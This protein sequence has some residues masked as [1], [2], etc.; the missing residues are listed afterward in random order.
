MDDMITLK[1]TINQDS[2]DLP[3]DGDLYVFLGA[4]KSTQQSIDKVH[5]QH[6]V[7]TIIAHKTLI[8]TE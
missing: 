4:I 7:C 3:G 1:D 6:V 2:A 5:L 8:P